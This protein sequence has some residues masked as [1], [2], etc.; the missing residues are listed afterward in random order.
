MTNIKEKLILSSMFL[1][2]ALTISGCVA[3]NEDNNTTVETNSSIS[4]ENGNNTQL[5]F[6]NNLSEAEIKSLLFV[7][8]EEKLARDVYLTLNKIWSSSVKVFSN[9]LISEQTHID[10]V[11]NLL[12]IYNLTDPVTESQDANL[13]IFQN[14]ELQELYN[15]LIAKG[16]KSIVDALQV[17]ATVEDYDIFDIEEHM[18]NIDNLD[19]LAVFDNLVKGSENHL[20]AFIKNLTNINGNYTPSYISQERYK[21]I[22][23]S[24]NNIADH[25]DT[26]SS[27]VHSDSN[28]TIDENGSTFINSANI[29]SSIPAD[30][31]LSEAE[32]KSL[33]FVREEEKLARDVYLGL[34]KIW[35]L[36]IKIFINI[37]KAE[38]SHTDS[39]K[40]LLSRYNL[41]DP[42]TKSEDANLGI[43]QNQELQNLYDS[44]MTKGEK[45]IVDALQVGA[46]VED[47]DI[48]D[49][50]E[51]MKNIDNLDILAVF[52]N[53]V[54]G[55]ENHLRSFS[56]SLTDNN[57]SYLPSYISQERYEL[58]VTSDKN[59][60][61][62]SNSNSG[63]GNGNG[64]TN[65][66]NS[67]S[68]NGNGNGSTNKTNSSSGNGNGNG[69]TNKTNSSSGNG[70]GNGSTNKTNS[71][72]GNGNG[73][74]STNS[75]K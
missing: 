56:K 11:K 60:T 13:G 54:K 45:S 55:S 61:N 15:S 26:N 40:A 47:Y 12:K 8:E 3:T 42:V 19:I 22:L 21:L 4:S 2:T 25:N 9:I 59:E 29:L 44:L 53:L 5:T 23:A 57:A 35:G 41:T 17:G 74:G 75:R 24:Q 1:A 14:Q 65:K 69:S 51:H 62:S 49:I 46:T 48:F 64:S 6:E 16:E 66:T 71:N 43:F 36:N 37:S 7:R 72:S 52:D 70:N 67:S 68:G 20:R 63:N 33:L 27:H 32:I 50:E 30:S 38:Q 18:K 10:S 58:I 39:V 34:D 31:N 28:L 73:N